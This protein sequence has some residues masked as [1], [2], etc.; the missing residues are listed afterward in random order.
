MFLSVFGISEKKLFLILGLAIL[1]DTFFAQVGSKRFW[2]FFR[3]AAFQ[4]K[5]LTLIESPNT[6]HYKSAKTMKV[7]KVSGVILGPNL[8]PCC[9]KKQKI[10]LSIGLFNLAWEIQLNTTCGG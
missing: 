6:F 9:E 1:T 5:L 10:A 3:T 7:G 4:Y 8:V 2:R